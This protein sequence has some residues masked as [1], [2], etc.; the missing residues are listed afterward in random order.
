MVMVPGIYNAII[1]L[2]S[3][4]A[5]EYKFKIISPRNQLAST[6]KTTDANDNRRKGKKAILSPEEAELRSL[7][8]RLRVP[9]IFV[10]S[11]I[12]QLVF[13]TGL[14]LFYFYEGTFDYI[15][16]FISIL[17]N[18]T[19][20]LL[21]P[22]CIMTRNNLIRNGFLAFLAVY[23]GCGYYHIFLT[24]M[25][26]ITLVNKKRWLKRVDELEKIIAAK[27]SGI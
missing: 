18:L 17:V 15:E 8:G 16:A 9:V 13:L 6:P 25:L 19:I 20:G 12:A 4:K 10:F 11:L 1:W 14:L 21:I 26:I 22:V 27:N 23:L 24:V 3:S 5:V 7:K 2:D